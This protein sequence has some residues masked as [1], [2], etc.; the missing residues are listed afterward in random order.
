MYHNVSHLSIVFCQPREGGDTPRKS[1]D[2][3][4]FMLDSSLRWNDGGVDDKNPLNL[5]RIAVRG[6][7][8]KKGRDLQGND[9]GQILF[10]KGEAEEDLVEQ[11]EGL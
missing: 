11:K 4:V 6:R 1:N 9:G 7:L 8:F 3:L 2:S 10:V 5:P